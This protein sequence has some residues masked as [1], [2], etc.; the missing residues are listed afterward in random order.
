ME[1]KTKLLIVVI[2]IL[3]LII[4][5]MSYSNFL[6]QNQIK[7]GETDFLMPSGY[8]EG[9]PTNLGHKNITDGNHSVYIGEYDD[10]NVVGHLNNMSSYFKNR[11]HTTNISNFTH[12]GILVYKLTIK[13]DKTCS[14]YYFEKNNATYT[15]Y[16]W[17][18]NENIEEIL[19]NL[20]NTMQSN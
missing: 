19:F 5:F 3:L 12:D 16:T 10:N 6:A 13:N 17:N 11:N 4:G 2:A 1:T 9:S 18:S 7:I 15:V 8:H 20:I 14:Y